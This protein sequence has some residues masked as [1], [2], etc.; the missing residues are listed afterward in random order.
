MSGSAAPPLVFHASGIGGYTQALKSA[1]NRVRA[2][3]RSFPVQVVFAASDCVVQTLEGAIHAR[4][5][6][7]V[8]TGPAGEQWPVARERFMDKY[9]SLGLLEP[10]ADG[11]YLSLP[12]EVLAVAMAVP[13]AVHLADGRSRLVGQPGD[14]LVDYG[15]GSLGVVAPAIFSATYEILEHF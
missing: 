8:V 4:A 1:P 2:R 14:W 6:D 13:F 10:G 15:D 5:G 7:A 9:Q 11:T 12:V 3:K